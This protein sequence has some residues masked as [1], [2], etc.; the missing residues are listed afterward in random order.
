VSVDADQ[1]TT[2]PGRWAR[3]ITFGSTLPMGR[4][5]GIPAVVDNDQIGPLASRLSLCVSARIIHHLRRPQVSSVATTSRFEPCKEVWR[6]EADE[7]VCL[8]T[9]SML[10]AIGLY[11]RDFHQMSDAEVPDFV[12]RAARLTPEAPIDLD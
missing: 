5:A 2:V 1:R 8:E 7:V 11:Y 6:E 4:R 10:G 12:A 3:L 9:P